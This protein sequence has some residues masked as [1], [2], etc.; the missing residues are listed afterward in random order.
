MLPAASACLFSLFFLSSAFAAET[1]ET[2]EARYK[3]VP[4]ERFFTGT[5]EAV[6]KATISAEVSGRI[7]E[8]LFDVDDYVPQHAV[9]VRFRARDQQAALKQAKAGLAEAS[10]RLQEAKSEYQRISNIFARKLVAKSR[11]DSAEASFKAAQA[12]V[13]AA[14]GRL[15]QAEEQLEHTQV[16]APY[17]GIVTKRFVEIGETVSVGQPLMAGLSLEQLR[18]TVQV[19]QQ[20]IQQ[21]RETGQASI[22]TD[23]GERLTSDALTLFPLANENHSFTVRIELPKG[24]HGLYPGMLVK[25]GFPL[26]QARRLL[27][28]R[29][30]LVQRSELTAVYLLTEEGRIQF[31]QIRVGESVGEQVEVLAGLEAG[32]Q[33]MLNPQQAVAALKQPGNSREN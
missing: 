1:P 16:R 29:R 25:A 17:A 14:R 19:P 6:N 13:E 22:L 8:L 3:N 21:I 33:V 12:R 4:V 10:A 20:L 27:I 32:E 31:R 9:I 2:S 5:I 23:A 18:A 11:L 15:A 28:D 30:A 26:E 7:E 24:Q